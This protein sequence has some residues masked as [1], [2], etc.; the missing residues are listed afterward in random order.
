VRVP[1]ALGGEEGKTR[2]YAAWTK[3]GL[4]RADGAPFSRPDAA[5][6]LWQPARGGPAFLLEP[7]FDAVYAYNPS[8]SYA[9]AL[10]H[11]G[12]RVVG[13]A[14]FVQAFPGSERPPTLAETQEIQRRLTALGFDT[15]GADGRVGNAT[16]LAAQRFQRERGMKPAD[17]Y[18]GVT[19]LERLRA[20]DAGSR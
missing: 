10:L 4:V 5:A 1:A 9:L 2:T 17:G 11:L 19:L 16:R 7:N 6:R 12:D 13:G 14:P 20:L 15:G 8:R 18:V 3:A